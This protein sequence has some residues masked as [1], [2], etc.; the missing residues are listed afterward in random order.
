[1]FEQVHNFVTSDQFWYYHGFVLTTLWVVVAT[2]GII[3]KRYNTVLHVL[4]FAIVDFTTLFF[5]GAAFYNVYPYFQYF[6]EWPTIKK[7]HIIG[8]NQ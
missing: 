7:G 2:M 8:G 1:M 6:N 3:L 5:A 4:S